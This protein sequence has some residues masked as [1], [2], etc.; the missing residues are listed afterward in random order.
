MAFTENWSDI[1]TTQVDADSPVNET[2][3]QSIRSD[4]IFLK[5]YL[6]QNYT[7]VPDHNHDG[8]NSAF[9]AS[10][11]D[12]SVT[13]PKLGGSQA[14]D[15]LLASAD[16]QRWTTS[17]SAVKLKE[18]NTFRGGTF[19][20]KWD[21]RS[22]IYPYISYAQVYINGSPAGAAQ[23]NPNTGYINMSVDIPGIKGD[24]LVQLYGWHLNGGAGGV[25]T[26]IQNFRMYAARAEGV[27][28]LID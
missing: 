2:L 8:V 27:V 10:V 26:Y 20:L 3:M 21:Q 19:R 22:S 14:G 13:Y 28:T 25:Y 16:T 24:D 7:P 12:G 18:I 9:I 23:T 1:L 17:T 5:E 11:G 4:L 6:A 15:V